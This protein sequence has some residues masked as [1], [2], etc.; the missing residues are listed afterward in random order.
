MH[1]R[2]RFEDW[3]EFQWE[4]ALREEDEAASR[5]FRL[6]QRFCDLPGG[7]RLIAEKMGPD[8]EEQL[9]EYSD[10]DMAGEDWQSDIDHPGDWLR[11]PGS[12]RLDSGESERDA[13]SDAPDDMFVEA[14][15]TF[16]M[17]RQTAI[18]WCNIYAAVLP[19]ESRDTGLQVLYHIGRALANL[20][21]SLDDGAYET[22]SASVAFAKRSLAHLNQ[23]IGGIQ[24]LTTDKPQWKKLLNAMRGHLLKSRESIL[25]NRQASRA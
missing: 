5:Y 2:D 11:F 23:A 17:L 25:E 3:S 8:F 1:N 15:P 21:N 12:D 4:I 22:P 24:K 7:D 16:V 20:A 18:G 13:P 10:D 14:D 6:L 19:Q 9:P